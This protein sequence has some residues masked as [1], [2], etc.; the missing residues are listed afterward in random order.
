M[1]R[2]LLPATTTEEFKFPPWVLTVLCRLITRLREAQR[3]ERSRVLGHPRV[4][5]RKVPAWTCLVSAS[6]EVEHEQ[7]LPGYC[8]EETICL[9]GGS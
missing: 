1:P 2:L 4:W 3:A 5:P 7:N 6:F 9:G 8:L